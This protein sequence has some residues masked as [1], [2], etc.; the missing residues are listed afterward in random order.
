LPYIR[1]IIDGEWAG[2]IVR[3]AGYGHIIMNDEWRKVLRAAKEYNVPVAIVSDEGLITSNEYAVAKPLYK[4][5]VNHSGTSNAKEAQIEMAYC[6]GHEDKRKSITEDVA[7]IFHVE[8]LNIV[9][10]MYVPGKLFKNTEQRTDWAH[11][12]KYSTNLSYTISPLFQ[13]E[14]KAKLAGLNHAYV[15][16]ELRSISKWI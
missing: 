16:G 13:W 12:H 10:A 2:I 7:E 8:P 4:A 1:G 15:S 14:E 3:G 11:T 5:G 9:S 6:V